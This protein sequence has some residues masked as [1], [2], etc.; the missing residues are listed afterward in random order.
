MDDLLAYE[1]GHT[2]YQAAVMRMKPWET[3]SFISGSSA[4]LI[5]WTLRGGCSY[6]LTRSGANH[7]NTATPSG[8]FILAT[9]F[10]DH[11]NAN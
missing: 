3:E 11:C 8:S 9:D 5:F 2:S 4:L 6:I 7:F 10:Y 1:L